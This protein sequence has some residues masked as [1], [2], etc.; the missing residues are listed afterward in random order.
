MKAELG[1]G[2]CTHIDDIVSGLSDADALEINC[3]L[4]SFRI[5]CLPVNERL[6][7]DRI[8]ARV[9]LT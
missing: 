7:F 5:E 4:V 9:G 1:D 8:A 3:P 2:H 6:V